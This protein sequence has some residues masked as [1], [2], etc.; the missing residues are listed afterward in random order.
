MEE[1]GAQYS[2][3]TVKLLC[4]D[5]VVRDFLFDTRATASLLPCTFQVHQ[6]M[7]KDAASAIEATPKSRK[8]FNH[9]INGSGKDEAPPAWG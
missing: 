9:A 8:W 3:M 7:H 6:D 1:Q 5:G 4:P 2:A